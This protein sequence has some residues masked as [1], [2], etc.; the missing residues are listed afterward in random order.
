MKKAPELENPLNSMERFLVHISHRLDIII[1]QNNSIVDFLAGQN[2]T[3]ITENKAEIQ[4]EIP[5]E[6]PKKTSKK[7]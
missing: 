7:K 3:P 2:N 1:E 4:V 5:I 6:K